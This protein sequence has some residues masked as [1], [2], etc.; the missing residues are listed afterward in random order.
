[1]IMRL[2]LLL[3]LF[4]FTNCAA[5]K[6]IATVNISD[7]IRSA[8]VD[9]VGEIYIVTKG[10]QIQKFD[11]NGKLLAVYRS[12][13]APTLF[14]PRDGSRLFAFYRNERKVEYLDPSFDVNITFAIDSA[15][16]IE[17]W[18]ACSSGDHDIWILDAADQTLKKVSP[19]NST[20]LA[21]V[22]FPDSAS[23]DDF[24]NIKYAREYQGFLF[25]LDEKKGVHLFSGMGRFIRTVSAA[26]LSYFNFLG[27]EMYYPVGKK[28]IFMNLFSGDQREMPISQPFETALLTDE[29]M[30]IVQKNRIDFFE[31]RP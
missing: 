23:T 10:H 22:K 24:A 28:L 17:P 3:S 5:Q 8:Y 26:S 27:E 25:L 2:A 7:D 13:L 19:R 4:Y 6:K 14:E 20:V 30:F 15:F 9:R 16:V 1:M 11:T 18:L 29:R 21:D 12:G 31:F